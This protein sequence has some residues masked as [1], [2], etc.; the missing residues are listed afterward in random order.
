MKGLCAGCEFVSCRGGGGGE[1][2]VFVFR[3]PQLRRRTEAEEGLHAQRNVPITNLAC[4]LLLVNG[5]LDC[6]TTSTTTTTATPT[7]PTARTRATLAY[8]ECKNFRIKE[9]TSKG[10]LDRCMQQEAKKERR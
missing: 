9:Q 5:I 6:K 4:K 10:G 1:T 2:R 3:R 8:S 7:V